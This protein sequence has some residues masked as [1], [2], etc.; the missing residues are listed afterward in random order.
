M[1]KYI[2][3]IF[4]FIAFVSKLAAQPLP[5]EDPGGNPVPVGKFAA[6]LLLVAFFLL[7]GKKD[8]IKNIFRKQETK[9]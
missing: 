1:K 8:Q 3:L 7:S 4:I 6:L 9:Q 5:P 2:S